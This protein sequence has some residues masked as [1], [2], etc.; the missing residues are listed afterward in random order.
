MNNQV[1]YPRISPELELCSKIMVDMFVGMYK[2]S[3]SEEYECTD[4]Y[5]HKVSPRLAEHLYD[6]S[7]IEVDCKNPDNREEWIKECT[8]QILYIS[9][10]DL[11]VTEEELL[12]EDVAGSGSKWDVLLWRDYTPSY[13]YCW[14]DKILTGSS[15]MLERRQWKTL[16]QY[17][18]LMQ[19]LVK[20][21][22]MTLEEVWE[23]M[24]DVKEEKDNIF[25]EGW[26]CKPMPDNLTLENFANYLFGDIFDSVYAHFYDVDFFEEIDEEYFNILNQ[27]LI[28]EYYSN[29]NLYNVY[30]YE[31]DSHLHLR[32][33][34][35][36][37]VYAGRFSFTDAELGKIE[38]PGLYFYTE[39][40]IEAMY[41]LFS[42]YL[43]NTYS[44]E[45]DFEG[46]E[47][48]G[49]IIIAH[50][51]AILNGKTDKDFVEQYTF[52]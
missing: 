30:D 27:E 6:H 12:E 36:K 24:N 48:I 16:L 42:Y 28:D 7:H 26:K 3:Y 19:R 47:I 11:P 22:Q 34:I 32:D 4:D 18:G 13:F 50:K 8:G 35:G 10:N 1:F 45:L 17:I 25:F 49:H 52:E 43:S 5:Y 41:R 2:N 23:Q 21:G 15:V 33:Y 20:D 37:Y 31:D 40:Y 46:T 9:H 44:P 39:S 38:F 51:L 29:S 14:I